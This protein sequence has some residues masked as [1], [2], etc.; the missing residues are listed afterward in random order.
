MCICLCVYVYSSWRL[1]LSGIVVMSANRSMMLSWR[2]DYLCQVPPSLLKMRRQ[3]F[4]ISHF[5]LSAHQK[6]TKPRLSWYV[7][8]FQMVTPLFNIIRH[9]SRSALHLSAISLHHNLT[10]KSYSNCKS[11]FWIKLFLFMRLL[12]SLI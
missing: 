11:Q 12:K 5:I 2:C 8:R 6:R 7:S 10:R 1:Y 9:C 3:N 4:L